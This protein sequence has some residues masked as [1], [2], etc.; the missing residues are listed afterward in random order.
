MPIVTALT[1]DEEESIL[2]IKFGIFNK[3]NVI[4]PVSRDS[5]LA[6]TYISIWFAIYSRA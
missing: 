3:E 6:G 4:G 5:N 2:Q 1:A